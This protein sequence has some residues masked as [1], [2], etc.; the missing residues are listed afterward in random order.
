M[1]LHKN[2]CLYLQYIYNT[3]LY[4]K[5]VFIKIFIYLWIYIKNKLSW[6]AYTL[7]YFGF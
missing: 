7:F 6:F 4:R 5:Y 3:Y 2:I 1:Y